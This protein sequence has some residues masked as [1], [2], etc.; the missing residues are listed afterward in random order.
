MCAHTGAEG[1]A[2]PGVALLWDL[3]PRPRPLTATGLPEKGG[4]RLFSA[5]VFIS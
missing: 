4:S 3:L 1:I 2:V 5:T